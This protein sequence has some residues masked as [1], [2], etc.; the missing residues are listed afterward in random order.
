MA[1]LLALLMLTHWLAAITLVPSIFSIMRP[2]FVARQ[3][4]GPQGAG[5]QPRDSRAR[6]A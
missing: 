3:S 4:E 6:V 5:D 2:V 1:L